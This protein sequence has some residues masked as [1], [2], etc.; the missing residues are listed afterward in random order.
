[1][2]S[3]PDFAELGSCT[4][5]RLVRRARLRAGKTPGPPTL[6]FAAVT[7]YLALTR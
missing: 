4:A 7:A 2:L 3:I 6:V 1:L 5:S